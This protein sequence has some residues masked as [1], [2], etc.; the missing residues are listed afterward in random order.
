MQ[1]HNGQ[2]ESLSKRYNLSRGAARDQSKLYLITVLRDPV[3]R[4]LSEFFF[5]RDACGLADSDQH[6]TKSELD[7]LRTWLNEY[8][9]LVYRSVCSRVVDEAAVLGFVSPGSP[10]AN[11][12]FKQ[13][14]NIE[15]DSLPLMVGHAEAAKK[16]LKKF[17]VVLVQEDLMPNGLALLDFVFGRHTAKQGE[18]T[19]RG[20]NTLVAE[21]RDSGEKHRRLTAGGIEMRKTLLANAS[22]VAALREAN[23]FDEVL[24]REARRLYNQHREAVGYDATVNTTTAT[25]MTK[26]VDGAANVLNHLWIAVLA[27]FVLRAVLLSRAGKKIMSWLFG[28][29]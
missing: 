10:I 21:I 23:S 28:K 27:V 9:P 12:Q 4:T 3:E 8:P 16:A 11:R 25:S 7:N 24:Y 5:V 6:Y 1:M 22:F 13:L 2:V 20:F 19:A 29:I 26:T 15:N 14:L 18:A 17:S